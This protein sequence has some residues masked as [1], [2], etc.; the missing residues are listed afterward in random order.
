MKAVIIIDWYK[1]IFIPKNITLIKKKILA[2]IYILSIY[3]LGPEDLF[4]T[5]T[6]LATNVQKLLS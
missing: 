4:T 2:I 3:I 6:M 5:I 1:D